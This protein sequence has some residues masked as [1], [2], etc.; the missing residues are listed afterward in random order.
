M[1]RT[2]HSVAIDCDTDLKRLHLAESPICVGTTGRR[3]S[4]AA[5]LD[6]AKSEGFKPHKD[7]KHHLCGPCA[8]LNPEATA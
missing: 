6:A 7:G 1:I 8:E 3:D 4:Q 2:Q 5:A